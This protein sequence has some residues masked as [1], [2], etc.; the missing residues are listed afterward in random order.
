M[1]EE[2]LELQVSRRIFFFFF[3]ISFFQLKEAMKYPDCIIGCN[4]SR[5]PPDATE[6]YTKWHNS[7][8]QERLLLEQYREC[9]IA[10][11]TWFCHRK[12][13]ER[14]GGYDE[15]GPGAFFFFLSLPHFSPQKNN[16]K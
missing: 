4:F 8:S 2:R 1:L 16:D 3:L 11:P 7:L 15:S 13:F 14:V 12:V 9:T 10:Q 5:D 6:R